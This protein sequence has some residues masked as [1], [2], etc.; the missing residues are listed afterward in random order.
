MA[1]R[2]VGFLRAVAVQH[3]VGALEALEE[4]LDARAAEYVATAGHDRIVRL[5]HAELAHVDF[6]GLGDEALADA[7][8]RA[9]HEVRVVRHL[10]HAREQRKDVAVVVEHG[11]LVEERAKLA[12]RRRVE[13]AIEVLFL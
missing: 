7:A 1:V 10:S 13:A 5:L 12:L 6:F 2:A 4:L 9:Q 8:R 11:A 3:E